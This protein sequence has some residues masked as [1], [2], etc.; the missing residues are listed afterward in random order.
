MIIHLQIPIFLV[1]FRF[2]FQYEWSYKTVIAITNIHDIF[3]MPTCPNCDNAP[4]Y[5]YGHF[6]FKNEG[7]GRHSNPFEDII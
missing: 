6:C 2:I 1:F 4:G 7:G 5:D 3:I